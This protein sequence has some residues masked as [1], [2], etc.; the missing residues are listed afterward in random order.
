MPVDEIPIALSAFDKLFPV[1]DRGWFREAWNHQS[2]MVMM[3][4]AAMRGIGAARRRVMNEMKKYA[5]FGFKDHTTN[6]LVRDNNVVA[7]ILDCRDEEL[8]K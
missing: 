7:R 4:P 8:V 2:R 3:M 6:D 5:D 1:G